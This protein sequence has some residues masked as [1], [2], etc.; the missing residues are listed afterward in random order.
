M[1]K[2]ARNKELDTRGQKIGQ[3]H[4][5][6]LPATGP[7]RVESAIIEV[8]DGP[9]WKEHAAALA[10]AEELVEV[11]V[12]PTTDKQQN[13]V[14]E[15]WNNGRVQRFIRGQPIV[16]KRKYVEVMARSKEISYTQETY[17]DGNGDDAIRMIPH[18]AVRYPFSVLVDKNPNGAA[19]LQQV[20][21]SY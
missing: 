4:P 20:L 21:A 2:A 13:I 18:T 11:I 17:K 10:F 7:A 9:E 19:W 12:H 1:A 8:V 3:D 16:V 5:R 14:V 6:E 15:I